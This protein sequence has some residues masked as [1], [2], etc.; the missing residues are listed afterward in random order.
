[1]QLTIIVGVGLANRLN[2]PTTL[3]RVLN[4]RL[5]SLP[6]SASLSIRLRTPRR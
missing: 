5:S 1:M 6:V 2:R 3:H 4:L